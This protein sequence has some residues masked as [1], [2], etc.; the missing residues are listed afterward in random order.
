MSCFLLF[1]GVRA[2]GCVGMSQPGEIDNGTRNANVRVACVSEDGHLTFGDG[3]QD[4]S[5]SMLSR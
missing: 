4:G 1:Y 3:E 5:S 2:V